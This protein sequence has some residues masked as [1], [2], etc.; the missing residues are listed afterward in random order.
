[1]SLTFLKL[2]S[3]IVSKTE[4]NLTFYNK[5]VNYMLSFIILNLQ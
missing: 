1:M 2:S 4:E 5:V 3:K